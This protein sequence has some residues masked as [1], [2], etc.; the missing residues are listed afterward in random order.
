MQPCLPSSL[1]S[2]IRKSNTL[3]LCTMDTVRPSKRCQFKEKPLWLRI[4]YTD[5]SGT[6]KSGSL[7]SGSATTHLAISPVNRNLLTL[8][9][10]TCLVSPKWLKIVPKS[11]AKNKTP[12][13]N[14]IRVWA[15]IRFVPLSAVSRHVIYCQNR[16]FLLPPVSLVLNAEPQP[17][18][19][20]WWLRIPQ[21]QHCDS[22]EYFWTH[23]WAVFSQDYQC[24]YCT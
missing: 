3:K 9:H 10:K 7:A 23:G 13:P 19:G 12:R 24:A 14:K 4:S 18:G 2:I 5:F 17:T 21:G 11:S 8:R 6:T 22:P 20:L 16:V 1:Y 15:I